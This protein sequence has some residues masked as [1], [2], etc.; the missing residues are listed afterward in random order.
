MHPQ[1]RSA[2]SSR[3]GI[4][5]RT[6]MCGFDS[7]GDRSR[8]EPC[9]DEPCSRSF[10]AWTDA[11]RQ[12]SHPRG[13]PN[14]QCL[15]AQSDAGFLD[16]TL[17]DPWGRAPLCQ[18]SVQQTRV[19]GHRHDSLRQRH[20]NPG[21]YSLMPERWRQ[22]FAT[23]GSTRLF[24]VDGATRATPSTRWASPPCERRPPKPTPA[25][26]PCSKRWVWIPRHT[27]R[28]PS[29]VRDPRE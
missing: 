16:T 18:P 22:G 21:G 19:E 3:P 6:W 27:S 5:L 13:G 1:S 23:E 9:P 17:Y 24:V 26:G 25:R 12:R 4:L 8:P 14:A 20:R 29:E 7:S 10:A 2:R 28:R 15:V 11:G